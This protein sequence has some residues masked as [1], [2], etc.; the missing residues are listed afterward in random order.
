MEWTVTID[1]PVMYTKPWAAMN[2]FPMKLQPPNL[3]IWNKYQEEMICSPS[4]VKA[5]DDSIGRNEE[6]GADSK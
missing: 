6:G 1:D 4:E 2:T 5:Y 3:D